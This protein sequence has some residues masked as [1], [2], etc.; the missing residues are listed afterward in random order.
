MSVYP[1]AT[2]CVAFIRWKVSLLGGSLFTFASAAPTGMHYGISESWEI[3][4][5]HYRCFHQIDFIYH[6]MYMGE[7]IQ[8]EA[9]HPQFCAT[10]LQIQYANI[11]H[12]GD[13]KPG[14]AGRKCVF[15]AL[16]LSKSRSQ[17]RPKRLNN[18][19][20]ANKISSTP[21]PPRR[22]PRQQPP[23]FCLADSR[24]HGSWCRLQGRSWP[25]CRLMTSRRWNVWA[26][27]MSA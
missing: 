15:N 20:D 16:S 23:S 18:N 26:V 17:R 11:S 6:D 24:V 25:R 14:R 3:D 9:P 4:R 2:S 5:C 7:Q 12:F 21:N 10:D 13:A 22:S 19:R 1:A 27:R 8:S